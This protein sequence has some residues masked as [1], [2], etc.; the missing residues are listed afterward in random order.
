MLALVGRRRSW[1]REMSLAFKVQGN[2]PKPCCRA[3]GLE[4]DPR[5]RWHCTI[6]LASHRGTRDAS[7]ATRTRAM[8]LPGQGSQGQECPMRQ[9]CLV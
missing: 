5:K 1:L 9:I 3:V 4:H 6:G 8:L 7:F 2:I